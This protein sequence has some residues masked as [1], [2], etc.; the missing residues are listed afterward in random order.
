MNRFTLVSQT[1]RP[2]GILKRHRPLKILVSLEYERQSD[3][4]SVAAWWGRHN[5][6]RAGAAPEFSYQW[7]IVV[8]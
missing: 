3:A 1:D 6:L 4:I 5:G 7:G 2:K 8:C